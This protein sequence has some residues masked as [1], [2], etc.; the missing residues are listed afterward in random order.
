MSDDFML[1][2]LIWVSQCLAYV[3]G[4]M[5]GYSI[6]KLKSSKRGDK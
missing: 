3:L 5:L 6:G 4:I 2:T 1:K